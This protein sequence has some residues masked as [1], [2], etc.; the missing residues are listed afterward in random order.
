MIEFDYLRLSFQRTINERNRNRNII[1]MNIL[2]IFILC[3]R[4]PFNNKND[5]KTFMTYY[6]T[7]IFI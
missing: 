6:N 5:Q 2:I 1:K 7:N 4:D 3:Q